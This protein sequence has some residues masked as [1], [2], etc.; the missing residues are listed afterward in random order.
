MKQSTVTRYAWIIVVG[1]F[2]LTGCGGG[3]S[4]CN[5]CQTITTHVTINGMS[6]LDPGATVNGNVVVPPIDDQTDCD[7]NPSGAGTFGG[8]TDPQNASF[9]ADNV[10]IGHACSWSIFRGTTAKCPVANTMTVFFTVPG[11]SHPIDCGTQINTFSVTPNPIDPTS[12]PTTITISGQNMYPTYA[13]PKVTFYDGNQNILLQVTAT[14]ASSDGTS[15]VAPASQVTFADG[16]YAAVIY[17]LQADGTWQPVGGAGIETRT[18]LSS[19]TNP[20]KPPMPCC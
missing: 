4:G 14:S 9:T 2:A 20:C 19:P 1:L 17:V 13:M 8:T 15:V 6:Q 7:I 12:P 3:S 16:F 5:N 10:A 11:G 18:P